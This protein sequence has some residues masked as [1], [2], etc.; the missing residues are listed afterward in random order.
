[1]SEEYIVDPITSLNSGT[2]LNGILHGEILE[3][4][5]LSDFN[6]M[7]IQG[8]KYTFLKTSVWSSSHKSTLDTVV[9]NHTGTPP[10]GGD[11]MSYQTAIVMGDPGTGTN[12]ID[13]TAPDP[14]SV[15]YTVT[16]PASVGTTGQILK[17]TNGSGTLDWVN[18]SGS[19]T[20]NIQYHFGARMNNQT[21]NDSYAVYCGRVD[22]ADRSNL[23]DKRTRAP[24]GYDG[25]LV[26]VSYLSESATTS[27]QM[28][29]YI[30]KVGQGTFSLSNINTSTELGAE[31]LNI[32]V[33]EKDFIQ[34]GHE[35]GQDPNQSFWIIYQ[36]IS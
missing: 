11:D 33:S 23:D 13:L 20:Q 27:T 25:T 22:E 5:S 29:I 21:G 6:G 35:G 36:E 31:T 10:P 30:N 9:T 15:N 2:I 18:P 32:S 12:T 19:F 1:M 3:E 7:N 8:T 16:F 24:V 28:Q 4:S 34:I 26:K 14:V 17:D